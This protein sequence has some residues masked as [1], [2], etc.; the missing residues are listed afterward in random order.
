MAATATIGI[1]AQA[2]LTGDPV[3]A[4]GTYSLALPFSYS[5]TLASG[6][7]ANQIDRIFHK[8]YSLTTTP[9]DIDLAGTLVDAFGNAVTFAEIVAIF[10]KNNS[11]TPGQNV[12]VGGDAAALVGWVANANDIVQVMPGGCMSVVNPNDPAYAVTGTTADILQLA[13]AA[14]TPTADLLVLGRSA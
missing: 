5:L 14:G 10:L 12:Q 8:R 6:T 4:G 11:A 3:G 1:T 9:T 13:A 2:T 7:A